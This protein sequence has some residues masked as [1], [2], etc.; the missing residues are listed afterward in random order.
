MQSEIKELTSKQR[1]E[2]LLEVLAEGLFF[3][4]RSEYPSSR[5]EK[6]KT[7]NNLSHEKHQKIT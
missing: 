4:F 3:V 2:L 5:D 6:A 7:D 1:F